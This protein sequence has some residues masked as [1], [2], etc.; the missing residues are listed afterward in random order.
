MWRGRLA[1]LFLALVVVGVLWPTVA[2]AV[3]CGDCCKSRTS[4]CGIPAT[5]FSL[6]CFHSA[7]TLPHV[8]PLG[9]VPL[10]GTR[11]ATA[12]E[13][14]GPPPCHRGILHVPRAFLT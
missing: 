7:S 11:L 4:A 2:G 9:F 8:P 13:T 1:W 3:S 6:C 12:D 10:E 14:G 5:G